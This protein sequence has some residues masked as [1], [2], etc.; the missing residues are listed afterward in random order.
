MTT[1][2]GGAVRS[3]DGDAVVND[4]FANH[5]Q[6]QQK[7]EETVDKEDE[8]PAEA[9]L[10]LLLAVSSSSVRPLR[11]SAPR[12][13]SIADDDFDEVV[14]T[15]LRN[16]DAGGNFVAAPTSGAFSGAIER[17]PSLSS[18]IREVVRL[19]R[20]TKYESS[21]FELH[22][23]ATQALILGGGSS[24]SASEIR[25]DDDSEND[26]STDNRW[27][28]TLCLLLAC[29]A[30]E[31]DGDETSNSKTATTSQ[32]T[33]LRKG[34]R[35]RKRPKRWQSLVY[36]TVRM[37]QRYSC[38]FRADDGDNDEGNATGSTTTAT[39]SLKLLS[40]R[41]RLWTRYVLPSTMLVQADLLLLSSS[42][43]GSS[44]AKTAMSVAAY[45]AGIVSTASTLARQIVADQQESQ[46]LHHHQQQQQQQLVESVLYSMEQQIPLI[47][48]NDEDGSESNNWHN[49]RCCTGAGSGPTGTFHELVLCHPWRTKTSTATSPQQLLK[50]R[51][52]TNASFDSMLLYWSTLEDDD[53]DEDDDAL[54]EEGSAEGDSDDRLSL[55][56]ISYMRTKWDEAGIALLAATSF[57][58]ARPLVWS[59]RY[60]WN[61]VYF[62]HVSALLLAS[63]LGGVNIQM[64]G[65]R[66]LDGLL[67]ATP[68]ASL[69]LY[70]SLSSLLRPSSSRPDCPVGTFQLLSNRIVSTS[71]SSS[72]ETPTTASP[73]NS[74][75]PEP[76]RLPNG[77]VAYRFMQ[78][79]LAKYKPRY[80]VL[81]VK[82]LV[83]DCPHPGL[84]P[85]LFDLLR[86]YI[87]Y[88]DEC[89]EAI[90]AVWDYVNAFLIELESHLDAGRGTV[91]RPAGAPSSAFR[92]RDADQLV[93]A[94]ELYMSAISLLELWLMIKRTRPEIPD[95]SKRLD[96]IRT[97]L[98]G[99]MRQ[100]ATTANS[101]CSPPPEQHFR[102]NVLKMTLDQVCD[103][104][105]QTD[106]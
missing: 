40:D 92:V 6:E 48:Q 55:D 65:Y 77:A 98:E 27:F 13:A 56:D 18:E 67:K 20:L 46:H 12:F 11:Q 25:R 93:D 84:R 4:D 33:L 32:T 69:C 51:L 35:K 87:H 26:G 72:P 1:T 105:R 60:T 79:L 3:N 90:G 54:S 59:S 91:D 70:G 66:L 73:G 28:T 8:D 7:Q 57:D 58:T 76:P 62:P 53:A 41:T 97:V 71:A 22:S 5:E 95:L 50:R 14:W 74:F 42:P 17:T 15:S 104:L 88:N 31:D 16:S 82:R 103:K 99:A 45:L 47:Q 85:K 34:N 86:S 39:S 43:R 102:L 75:E 106:C 96:A 21:P 89:Q 52:R 19:A 63:D 64:I 24:A 94:T 29:L 80:Q 10:H 78:R 9:L 49:N 30:L 23:C 38:G 83:S 37:Y 100:W 68:N 2:K 101:A 61:A 36:E 81:L 44:A